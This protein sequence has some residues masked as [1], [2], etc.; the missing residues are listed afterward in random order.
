M[1]LILFFCIISVYSFAQTQIDSGQ[2][3]RLPIAKLVTP[4]TPTNGQVIKYNS[5]SG[6]W[7]PGTDSGG[8]ASPGGSTTQI[9]YNNA[10]SFAGDSKFYFNNT[11]KVLFVPKIEITDTTDNGTPAAAVRLNRTLSN[12]ISSSGHGFR[13]QTVFARP[14]FAYAAFDDAH[15]SAVNIDHSIS[16]QG[17]NIHSA[18]TITDLQGAGMYPS[19][20][21]GSATNIK[22][23]ESFPVI[24][25][26]STTATNL[27]GYNARIPSI[28]GG[29]TLTNYYAFY[30]ENNSAATNNYAFYQ[31]A[32]SAPSQFTGTINANQVGAN[33]RLKADGTSANDGG[34]YV[35]SGGNLNFGNWDATKGF[36][37]A[38]ATG[39]IAQLGS[40]TIQTGRIGINTTPHASAAINVS[41]TG[42]ISGLLTLN[43]TGGNMRF[44][45]ANTTDGDGAILATAGGD[46]YYSN[47]DANKGIIIKTSTGNIN[48]LG[49]GKFGAGG[50]TTPTAMIHAAASTTSAASYR[51]PSGTAPTSPNEGDLWNNGTDLKYYTGA[52]TYDLARVLKGS[53]TLDF[54]NTSTN[55]SS[56]LTITVT[57]AA[58]GDVVA[59]GVP[60]GSI[61]S[62]LFFAW[63]SAANTVTV[64]F[65]NTSGGGVDPASG[66]FKVTVTK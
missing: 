7:E 36:S 26:A 11:S 28:S 38:G 40:G 15:T 32:G 63:V 62:G 16:F 42:I 65:H 1:K 54:P 43:A 64:R 4:T 53:A 49:S 13:D 2:I 25:G 31:A 22:V 8:S 61:T 6:K 66:T 19:L 59:L 33:I 18:G 56:D 21:G 27:Y 47:W 12:S 46:I 23:Y 39:N 30:V 24:S 52:A 41:G 45:G 14:T 10:G 51:V 5:T 29:A 37:I 34:F 58:D 35:S 60:N 17:R 20:T 44:K 48:T 57:G 55:S 3:R 9:Q 50:V